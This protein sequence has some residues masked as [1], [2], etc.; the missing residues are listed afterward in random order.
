MN[1]IQQLTLFDDDAVTGT[2]RPHPWPAA[3]PEAQ[4]EEPDENPDQLA[5][6]ADGG[7]ATEGAV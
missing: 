1:A 2:G 6:N 3:A 7:T 4:P 5:F